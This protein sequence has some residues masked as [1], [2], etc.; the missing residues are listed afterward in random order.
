MLVVCVLTK[1]TEGVFTRLACEAYLVSYV[2]LFDWFMQW[3]R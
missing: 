1:V 2:V 3:I